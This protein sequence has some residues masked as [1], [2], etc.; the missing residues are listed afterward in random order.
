MSALAEHSGN[1]AESICRICAK[2][3]N[4]GLPKPTLDLQILADLVAAVSN[5]QAP[6]SPEYGPDSVPQEILDVI[7]RLPGRPP[8]VLSYEVVN[9]D[10]IIGTRLSGRIAEIHGDRGLSANSIHI[11]CHGSAGLS[12]GCFLVAGVKIELIGEAND[13]VGNGIVAVLGKTG[14]NFGAGMSGSTAYV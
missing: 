2:D 13:Y 4:D 11:T 5:G 10:R 7:E 8:V 9:T 1:S 14:K 6:S 3:R 12:F